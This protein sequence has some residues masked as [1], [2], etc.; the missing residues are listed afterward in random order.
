MQKIKIDVSKNSLAQIVYE[1]LLDRLM[2]NKLVPGNILN[3]REI[4]ESR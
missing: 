4:A 1:K 3:R 2:Q